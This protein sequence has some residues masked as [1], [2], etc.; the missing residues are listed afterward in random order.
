MPAN[1]LIPC[2]GPQVLKDGKP[3]T[4]ALVMLND[5]KSLNECKARHHA[6]SEVIKFREKLTEIAK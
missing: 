6:L 3:L 4:L 1:L 2:D 5:A